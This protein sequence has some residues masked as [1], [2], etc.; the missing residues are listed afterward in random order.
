M[1]CRWVNT[2]SVNITIES[3]TQTKAIVAIS[4]GLNILATILMFTA[5]VFWFVARLYGI[6]LSLQ[7]EVLLPTAIAILQL[8]LIIDPNSSSRVYLGHSNLLSTIGIISLPFHLDSSL[9]LIPGL[10]MSLFAYFIRS[11]KEAKNTEFVWSNI[12]IAIGSYFVFSG[13]WAIGTGIQ[14]LGIALTTMTLMKAMGGNPQINRFDR[15][16][17][18]LL[19]IWS[20]GLSISIIY[21]LC[22]SD[23]YSGFSFLSQ[24]VLLMIGTTKIYGRLWPISAPYKLKTKVIH[25]SKDRQGIKVEQELP[26]HP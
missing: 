10:G 2:E 23:Y 24:G 7:S 18:L 21:W 26:R 6:K 1:R 4:R 3:N 13:N 8:P 15:F 17:Y 12:L 20:W 14:L 5:I 22:L 11:I 25:S 16:S 9:F 19:S